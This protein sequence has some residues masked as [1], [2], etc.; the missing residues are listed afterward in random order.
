MHAAVTIQVLWQG[1]EKEMPACSWLR[2]TVSCI[3]IMQITEVQQKQG[4]S[5]M[6]R[7]WSGHAYT[8]M[9]SDVLGLKL[10][11]QNPCTGQGS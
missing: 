6:L 8:P 10:S 3:Y 2:Q 5:S 9:V 11:L 1:S 7:L 4:Q